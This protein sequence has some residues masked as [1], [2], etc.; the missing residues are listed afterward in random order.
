MTTR[1]QKEYDVL[2]DQATRRHKE[3]WAR[4]R[5]NLEIIGEC[6]VWT[7]AISKN[8]YPRMNIR[9]SNPRR[10]FQ[11][12]MHRAFLI[13]QTHAPIPEGYE[14]GHYECHNRACVRHVRLETRQEN[15]AARDKR[16]RNK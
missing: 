7:G 14:A 4:I 5:R 1:A 9:L 6:R 10:T 12:E 16:R 13:M 3:F 11:L 2:L 8:G 15:L